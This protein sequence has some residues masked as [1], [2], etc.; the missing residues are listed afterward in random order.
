MAQLTIEVEDGLLAEMVTL[1]KAEHRD[2]AEIVRS[3][4]T[5]YV[6]D[7][8]ALRSPSSVKV[9]GVSKSVSVTAAGRPNS[10]LAER[11]RLNERTSG[12]WK[13]RDVDGLQFQLAQRAE[14]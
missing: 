10:S 2:A 9:G 6:R 13:D 14:W 11:K 4:I 1:A 7:H 3:A 12:M 5:Q 8:T